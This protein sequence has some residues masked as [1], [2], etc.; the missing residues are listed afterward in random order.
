MF[1]LLCCIYIY[2]F[3]VVNSWKFHKWIMY[4]VFD[5]KT[6]LCLCQIVFT[7]ECRL[8]NCLYSFSLIILV[9][10]TR[11]LMLSYTR[12]CFSFVGS[13][14][15]PFLVEFR[16]KCCY[17]Y[18]LNTDMFTFFFFFFLVNIC[19]SSLVLMYVQL[20]FWIRNKN[21]NNHEYFKKIFD[22]TPRWNK[23]NCRWDDSTPGSDLVIFRVWT[24]QLQ[25]E[26]MDGSSSWLL[27]VLHYNMIWAENSQHLMFLSGDT[28]S[29]FIPSIIHINILST[30]MHLVFAF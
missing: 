29:F 2:Y 7:R 22:F 14:I 9:Y 28:N 1:Q 4:S 20:H 11:R 25:S 19:S 13:K 21:S 24:H 26:M 8:W 3:L 23:F 15:I 27:V 6:V 30:S 12:R 10:K 18:A 16:C 5:V 17:H